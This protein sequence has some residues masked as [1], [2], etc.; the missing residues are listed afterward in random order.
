[1]ARSS[2]NIPT[3]QITLSTTPHVKNLLEAIVKSGL[4]GKNAAEAAERL[5][6]RQLEHLIKEGSLG[7]LKH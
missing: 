5:V 7:K 6:A 4:Y 2:N 1:M 3:V